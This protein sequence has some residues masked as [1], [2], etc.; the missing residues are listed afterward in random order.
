MKAWAFVIVAL[1]A[2]EAIDQ[3]L[4]PQFEQSKALQR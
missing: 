1:F 2:V 3:H 4:A